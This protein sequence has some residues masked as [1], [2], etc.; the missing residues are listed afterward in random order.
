MTLAPARGLPVTSTLLLEY[1]RIERDG[2]IEP[3]TSVQTFTFIIS[4]R[5]LFNLVL[6]F[7]NVMFIL[8][9]FKYLCRRV[10][11]KV[12]FFPS[13]FL[14]ATVECYLFLIN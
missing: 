6:Y 12:V 13:L 10:P 5:L 11:N 9:L 8:F 3:H 2:V 7:F 4:L 1:N 14:K